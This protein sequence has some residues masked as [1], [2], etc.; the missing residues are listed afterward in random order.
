M[1]AARFAQDPGRVMT[2]GAP[3]DPEG[4]RYTHGHHPSVVAQHGRRSAEAD[5]A[6][7]LPH[8][9]AGQRLLDVGCGPGS[10]TRGLA[11][12]VA[13]GETIGI[14]VSADVLET[15]RA[16]EPTLRFELG[17]VYA[18]EYADASFDVAHAHQVLQHLTRPIDALHELRRVLRPGGIVAVRDGDYATMIAWPRIPSRER[19]LGLYQAVA[20]RNGAEP[21][22]GRRLPG[23]LREAGFTRIQTS[24]EA[25]PFTTPEA[26]RNWGESWAERVLHSN[27]AQHALQYGLA[28]R[29]ELNEIAEGWRIWARDPDAFFLYVNVACIGWRD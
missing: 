26:V 27:L 5:A 25:I 10:I 18:L 1:D 28:T 4:D 9:R 17:D 16:L 3:P 20:R 13:P 8:L 23:W 14:D 24:A 19:W 21:D 11:R 7:V 2:H 15:A 22:A 29:E 12:A 6:Y